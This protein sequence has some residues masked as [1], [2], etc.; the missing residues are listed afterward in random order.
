M[1]FD[2]EDVDKVLMLECLSNRPCFSTRFCGED[3]EGP[4]YFYVYLRSMLTILRQADIK[5]WL[6]V[7]R[8]ETGEP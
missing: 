2:S 4:A 1:E 8:Q 7:H 6:V 5:G 3:S